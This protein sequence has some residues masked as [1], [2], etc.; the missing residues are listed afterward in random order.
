MRL[1]T[2]LFAMVTALCAIWLAAL[3]G[4]ALLFDYLGLL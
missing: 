2:I 4:A 3:L 1:T